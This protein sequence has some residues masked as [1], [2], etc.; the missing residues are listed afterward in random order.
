[1][2]SFNI[3]GTCFP[4]RHYMV[5]I[6]DRVAEIKKMVDKNQ[7]FCINR[8]R[9]YG[10][11]TTLHALRGALADDYEI[12]AISFEG[13]DLASYET[14]RH[15]AYAMLELMEMASMATDNNISEPVHALVSQAIQAYAQSRSIHLN[16]LTRLLI[17]MNKAAS[18]PLV[19][20]IDEVDQASNY[21]AFVRILGVLRK[22][23]LERDN[24]PTFQSVILAGVYDI[25]NLKLKIRPDAE[26]AYNSPWNIATH[27]EVDMGFN[28]QD[29]AGMLQAYENDHHTGMDI[30]TMAQRIID[31]TGGYPFLVSRLC[32]ILD[33]KI[34]HWDKEGILKA[35]RWLLS[36]RNTLFDD[37]IKKLDNFPELSKTL[38]A[39]LYNGE[40]Y[41]YTPDHKTFNLA[42]LFGYIRNNDHGI[43][44]ISN[45][46]FEMRLYN[47]FSSKE[48]SSKLYSSGSID[49]NQCIQ[50][51][52]INMEYLLTRFANHFNEIYGKNDDAFVEKMGRK[53]FLLYLK[54]IINGI[55]NYYI[56]AQTRDETRTDVIIDY[57]SQ[58]Y[59]IEL[60]I[61]RGDAYN[62]RGEEQ[63]A[64][65]LDYFH[66]KK[67]YLLSFCFNKNKTV[68]TKTIQVRDKTIF[69]VVV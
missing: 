57:L 7:Y 33:E 5:D 58:Q 39:I 59:I 15:L 35:E 46:I 66:A 45:R 65:Y 31:E 28:V 4:D 43:V 23:Y 67:G 30:P 18:K 13:L 36:E 48:E 41:T 6:T 25:K 12:Y 14:D 51:N 32:M 29:V 26:H 10:K 63:I 60:K 17:Q 20:I 56:E 61:W 1:M 38:Q 42:K 64:G 3:T 2:K 44:V 9:Q 21:D 11:T 27:F 54:P 37:L 16:H 49:K 40:K 47:F 8:A 22:Q 24:M 19:L 69:E 55:G 62:Q 68:E 52:Q 34:K 50:N 53:L